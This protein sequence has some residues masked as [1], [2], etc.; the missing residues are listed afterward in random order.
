MRFGPWPVRQ[1]NA[2]DG[3]EPALRAGG[4][5]APDLRQPAHGGCATHACGPRV[6]LRARRPELLRAGQRRIDRSWVGRPASAGA[7]RPRAHIQRLW[8]AGDEAGALGL[9]EVVE[10]RDDRREPARRTWRRSRARAVRRPW[11]GRHL[12]RCFYSPPLEL[13]GLPGRRLAR[14]LPPRVR[15]RPNGRAG[16]STRPALHLPL[17][18]PIC[19]SPAPL[20]SRC[21]SSP[22]RPSRRASGLWLGSLSHPARPVAN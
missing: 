5:G 19:C 8:A 14:A 20:L 18:L 1:H 7:S 4:V 6:R 22:A 17:P 13:L 11:A 16:P 2:T 10:H 21:R 12:S 9:R 3:Y 15:A